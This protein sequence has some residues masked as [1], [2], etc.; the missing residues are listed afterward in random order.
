MA[1]LA[2][3]LQLWKHW[4]L[5]ESAARSTV[6]PAMPLFRS[7]DADETRHAVAE[8]YREHRLDIMGRPPQ[9]D[10]MLA[11]FELADTGFGYVGYGSEV[12]IRPGCL[13]SFYVVQIPVTGT[14]RVRCGE[15]EAESDLR[16]PAILSATGSIVQRWSRGCAHIALRIERTALERELSRM[17]HRELDAPVT[18]EVGMD[19]SRPAGRSW[20]AVMGFALEEIRAG[21]GALQHP[22]VQ[23]RVEQLLIDLLLLA[24]PNNFSEALETGYPPARPPT[25]RRAVEVIQAR[26][27]E[28]LTVPSLAEL[29][30]AS[31]RS[32]QQGFRDYLGTTP[33][34]Y[35]RDVRLARARDELCA[36]EPH[37][38]TS[39]TDVAY[40]WGF[41]HLARFASY[42]K[43]RYGELPS[44]T[45]RA[46]VP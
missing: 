28:P 4:V 25:V 40:R 2:N 17:M 32:L 31:V 41:G 16:A 11:S 22:L 34:Q 24:Q 8:V 7:T 1:S 23:S 27:A 35:L 20:A 3:T 9:L 33:L 19:L 30:G 12:L 44:E 26:A 37:D 42:Y 5:D 15:S 14:A 38:G 36:A 45:L 13:G 6:A 39:V 29:V 10:A 43:H 18:F 46:P 21:T